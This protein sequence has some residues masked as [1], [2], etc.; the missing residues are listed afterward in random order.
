MLLKSVIFFLFELPACP[1]FPAFRFRVVVSDNICEPIASEEDWDDTAPPC[2]AATEPEG[3]VE[4][5]GI[6]CFEIG[7]KV[8]V[9][10]AWM[11]VLLTFPLFDVSVF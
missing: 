7:T 1:A 8:A 9:G 2:V 6:W 11:I 5:D 10:G 3:I 4:L